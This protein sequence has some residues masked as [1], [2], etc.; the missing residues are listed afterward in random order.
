MDLRGGRGERCRRL[1]VSVASLCFFC[2]SGHNHTGWHKTGGAHPTRL[3]DAV[4]AGNSFQLRL[5]FL[6]AEHHICA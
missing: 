1:G 6:R 3:Q 2:F 5:V 4:K